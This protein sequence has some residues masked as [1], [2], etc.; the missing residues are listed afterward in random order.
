MQ[1]LTECQTSSLRGRHQTQHVC[2]AVA[3]E[4]SGTRP[5]LSAKEEA[6]APMAVA[7]PERELP[8]GMYHR[9][10]DLDLGKRFNNR[11]KLE[12]LGSV[13]IFEVPGKKPKKKPH[14]LTLRKD[15][16][17]AC[18]IDWTPAQPDWGSARLEYAEWEGVQGMLENDTQF[19]KLSGEEYSSSTVAE[20][21]L[22]HQLTSPLPQLKDAGDAEALH[23]RCSPAYLRAHQS[24][25]APSATS[26]TCKPQSRRER[27]ASRPNRSYHSFLSIPKTAMS[28]PQNKSG[29]SAGYKSSRPSRFN[30]WTRSYCT[31]GSGKLR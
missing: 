23:W 3:V 4:V 2:K 18:I 9:M 19:W 24:P 26:L 31:D 8:N 22:N 28:S 1:R 15:S 10:E 7:V 25:S 30:R 12:I 14:T 5:A 17:N 29:A 27:R 13:A 21:L 11:M 16:D 6:V 20:L